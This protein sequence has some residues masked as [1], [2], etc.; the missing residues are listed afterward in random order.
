MKF[1][2]CNHMPTPIWIMQK[3]LETQVSRLLFVL[4][5]EEKT[6]FEA[7]H[8]ENNQVSFVID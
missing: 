6:S 5:D 8:V 7:Q 3:T 4:F 2:I 1:E